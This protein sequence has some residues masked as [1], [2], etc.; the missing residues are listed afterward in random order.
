M[1]LHNL[2]TRRLAL[3]LVALAATLAAC[4]GE[5][6]SPDEGAA[7]A[8]AVREGAVSDGERGGAESLDARAKRLLDEAY[9]RCGALVDSQER[10]DETASCA[11]RITVAGD[12][13]VPVDPCSALSESEALC[14][15]APSS[16]CHF[17]RW[18]LECGSSGDG[19]R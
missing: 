1:S 14:E 9:R 5:E 18:V 3:W 7:S 6:P 2:G 16:M 19:K 13:C 11:W 12:S 10:C 8:S 4:A 17:D 15:A